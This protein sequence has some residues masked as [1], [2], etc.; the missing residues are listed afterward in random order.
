LSR[1]RTPSRRLLPIL[2]SCA[3]VCGVTAPAVVAV[4][5]AAAAKTIQQG[6][7]GKAV[8]AL[9]RKLRL[10]A[11]GVW[12]PAT[13]RALKR[14]QRRNGLTATGKLDVQTQQKLGLATAGGSSRTAKGVTVTP[15]L[16]KQVQTVIGVTPDG[17]WGAQSKAALKTWEAQNG[18]VADGVIDP[19]G[20]A[21][22][23]IDPAATD[24]TA[25]A[26]PVAS[27]NPN[28]QALVA[29][30]R[31]QIGVPY[32]S[33]GTTPA[34]FDCSGL[35]TYVFK[36]AGI[37]LKRTSFDQF[38]QGTAVARA[39]IQP[40]DLV[41]FNTAGAGASHVGVAT[42][43]TTVVSATSHGVMEHKIGDAYWGAHYVGARRV[44]G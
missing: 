27:T 17:E 39:D 16:L 32:R 23:G 15:D 35:T 28:A 1:A 29:A 42:S 14:F 37:K 43:P 19:E 30:A 31:A 20:L 2:L 6:S 38:T 3:A 22:M 25:T 10:K 41:F 13:T 44:T 9:Q 33:G 8:K 4:P 21:K 12:G 5:T 11:D 7:R 40:G 34:G 18:L 36:Q 24:D 26:A